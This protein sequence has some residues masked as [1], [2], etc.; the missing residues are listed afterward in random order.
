MDRDYFG[1]DGIRGRVGDTPITPDFCVHLGWAVGK[2]LASSGAPLVVIGKDTRISGYMI[3]SALEAGLASAGVDVNL[4]GPIPTP[5]IAYLTRTLRADAGIVISASHN[6]FEDNGIKFFD[7]D[8]NK[9]PDEMEVAIE[10]QLRQPVVSVGAQELGRAYR[11]DDARGRY[12][13]FCKGTIDRGVHFRGLKLVIDCAHGAT[14]AVA[15]GVFSELGADVT[16]I[17]ADPDGTNINHECGSTHPETVAR[18]VVETGADAGIAFDGDGDRVIM[19]DANG[20]IVDGDEML[21]VIAKTGLPKG[22]LSG[23]VVGTVMSNLGLERALE[24]CGIPFERAAVGD[25]YVLELMR[26]RGWQ[27]GGETSGHL[28]CLALTTT[29]DGIVSALQ[30]LVAMVESGRSLAELRNGMR[31]LPQAMVNVR[32]EDPGGIAANPLVDDAIRGIEA[33]L[34]GRGRVVIRPSGTEPVVRVMVEGEDA[35]EVNEQA[36]SLAAVVE[37][38]N[39]G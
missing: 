4:F 22:R 23:G 15:P 30:V 7:A 20:D 35:D 38:A 36:A 32:I 26:A 39:G 19:V 3:E 12:I 27:L 14:Y 13:E 8:G 29:G 5:A 11:V 2:V 1:T 24:T 33:H 18:K 6:P 28:V 10:A 37:Q 31:K 34:N 21:Y 9:L 16:V 17:G 25:R